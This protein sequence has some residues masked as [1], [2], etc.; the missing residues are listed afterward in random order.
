MGRGIFGSP[1]GLFAPD[2]PMWA[3]ELTASQVVVVRASRDRKQVRSQASAHLPDGAL[4]P[5]LRDPNIVDE[6]AVRSAVSEA[7]AGAGFSGSEI[8]VV[9]PDDAVRVSVLSVDSF[10]SSVK[11]QDTFIR[12]KLKKS[13]PFDIG[14]A[15]LAYEVI[16]KE[17][18]L[19]LLVLLSPRS[20][21]RQYEELMESLGLHPGIVVPSTVAAFNLLDGLDGDTLFVKAAPGV[22]TT[23]I[24]LDGRLRFY[25]KIPEQP[26]YEAVYPTFMYYQDKLHGERLHEVVFCGDEGGAGQTEDLGRRLEVPVRDLLP[27]LSAAY[28]PALAALRA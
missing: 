4:R 27:G 1:T 2:V 6:D 10:P 9:I 28:Q 21:T 3:C 24:F 17:P 14:N 19:E 25:R 12:W 20:V 18:A 8:A 26:L 16:G 13:V 22:I 5:D 7:L 11:E 23:S 15:A